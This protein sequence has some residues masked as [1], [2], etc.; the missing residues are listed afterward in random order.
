MRTRAL[1]F[2]VR[3]LVMG[4]SRYCLRFCEGVGWSSVEGMQARNRTFR[5]VVWLRTWVANQRVC[6]ADRCT[7]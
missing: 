6:V 1:V 2:G 7:T 3:G 5:R 4:A